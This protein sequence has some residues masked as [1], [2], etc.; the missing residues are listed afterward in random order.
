[1]TEDEINVMHTLDDRSFTGRA[2]TRRELI[3]VPDVLAADWAGEMSKTSAARMAVRAIAVAPMLHENKA[4]GTI[5]VTRAR[6]VPFS[7][8]ELTLLRTFANQAVIALEN[9]RLFRELQARNRD[10]TE[11]LQQ[12]TASAEILRVI[13]RS[14]TDVQ[15]VFD[16]IVRNA[17]LLCGS[18]NGAV[19]V[20]RSY[21][22]RPATPCRSG[23]RPCDRST[24]CARTC[25]RSP[26]GRS[27]RCP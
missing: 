10:L 17:V 5:S 1:V 25:P 2:I 21:T 13:S 18:T 22:T 6:P 8:K 27:S 15:P 26:D 9:V 23:W 14:P 16:T 12:Q 3:H 7:T 20:F 11:A 4:L 19:A 24:R